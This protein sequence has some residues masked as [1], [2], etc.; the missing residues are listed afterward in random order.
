MG[1]KK[2]K[3]VGVTALALV[4]LAGALFGFCVA[5]PTQIPTET[6]LKKGRLR[7][8]PICLK[9]TQV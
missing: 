2:L 9:T 8:M 3:I 4:V 7:L 1:N 5:L 6:Y